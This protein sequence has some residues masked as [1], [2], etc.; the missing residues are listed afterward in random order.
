MFRAKQVSVSTCPVNVAAAR[1]EIL[2]PES[3]VT[4]LNN[5]SALCSPIAP[6]VLRQFLPPSALIFLRGLAVAV[7]VDSNGRPR[8]A[9]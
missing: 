4:S 8:F 9:E 3:R 2:A 1:H 7:V 6:S 5:H